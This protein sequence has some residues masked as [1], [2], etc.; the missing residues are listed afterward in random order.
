MGSADRLTGDRLAT[1]LEAL[2]PVLDRLAWFVPQDFSHDFSVES[3]DSLEWVLA[4]QL[5]DFGAPEAVDTGL[6]DSAAA[7]LGEALM[8]V[9]GGRWVWDEDPAGP[10]GSRPVVRFDDALGLPPM[11]P[12]QLMARARDAGTGTVFR[13][14]LADL[15]E[16]VGGYQASHPGW[17]P[18]TVHSSSVDPVAFDELPPPDPWL[19]RWLASRAADFPRWADETGD[20]REWQFTLETID[21]LERLFLDRFGTVEK[22]SAPASQGFVATASWLLGEILRR[23]APDSVFWRYYP[24]PPGYADAADYFKQVGYPC[25]GSPVI[26]R[27]PDLELLDPRVLLQIVVEERRP[28]WLRIRMDDFLTPAVPETGSDRMTTRS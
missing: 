1:W 28:G 24:V 10:A 14:A 20:P 25:V 19:S 13:A 23:A 11:S 5:P 22:F 27:F 12:L 4:T 7:Y 6:A 18:T 8:R 17:T 16:T 9:G 15:Q 26:G 3:L 21:G 2:S